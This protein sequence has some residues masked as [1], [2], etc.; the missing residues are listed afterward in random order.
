MN[1]LNVRGG[2]VLFQLTKQITSASILATVF[3]L[4]FFSL[5]FLWGLP[6]NLY[7]TS[8]DPYPTRV[9]LGAYLGA[10]PISLL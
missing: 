3:F 2:N 9:R 4:I 10:C 5:F 8:S 7:Y 6:F 1:M